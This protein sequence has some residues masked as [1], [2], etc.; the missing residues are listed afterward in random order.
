MLKFDKKIQT[1]V[2]QYHKQIETETALQESLPMVEGMK[3]RD[4]FLLSVGVET[5]I[6]MNTLA[7]SA[8][9]KTIL[10]IGTS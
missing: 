1:V 6:F 7:K 8:K 5:A 3:R 10:E 2:S 9:S 4:E